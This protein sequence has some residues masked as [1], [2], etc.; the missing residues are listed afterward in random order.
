[1]VIS[2]T[3]NST[4]KELVDGFVYTALARDLWLEICERF[5][6]CNSLMI[7]E[8][9]RNFSLIFQE[10]ASISVYFTKLKRFWDEL[11]SMETLPTCTCGA[12]RA[13]A[14]ITNIN[15]LIQFLMDLNEFFESVRDQILGMDSLLIVNKAYTKVVKFE[16]QR[17]ILGAMNDNSE[18]L[19]LFNK[20]Y[21][22]TQ[23]RSR[24]LDIK[25]GML[26][27]L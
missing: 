3:L 24:R 5:G 12:S 2:W 17:E 21:S 7:Y 16:S 1:M 23:I 14:E 11:S 19:V 22:Q 20:T 8:L 4:S 26:Q 9:Y 6:E 25:K 27:F 13:I 15:K 10:N 18:S